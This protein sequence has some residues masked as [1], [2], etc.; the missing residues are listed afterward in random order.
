[1]SSNVN[2]YSTLNSEHNWE[3]PC[4]HLRNWQTCTSNNHNYIHISYLQTTIQGVVG[5]SCD[6][7]N[8]LCLAIIYL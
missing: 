8:L 2:N 5:N 6:G 7:C 3:D 4:I 1:M